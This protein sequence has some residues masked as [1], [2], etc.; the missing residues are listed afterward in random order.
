[1]RAARIHEFGAPLVVEDVPEPHADEGEQL[2][3]LTHAGVNPLDLRVGAGGAGRVPLPFIPGCDGVGTTDAGP[4]VVYG[5]GIGLRRPGTYAELVAAPAARLVPVPPGVAATQAAGLGMAAVTAYGLVHGRAAIEN[6]ERVLVL[7]ASG[8][9]GILTVQLLRE[10]RV[11]TWALCSTIADAEHIRSLGAGEV[12]VGGPESVAEARS[13]APTT[14]VDPLGGPFTGAA[15]QVVGTGGRIAVLGS[16]A[17]TTGALDFGLLYRKAA[18]V[19]GHAT[20]AMSGTQ[21]R[22]ALQHCLDALATGRLA[23]HVDDVVGLDDVEQAH[24]RLRLRRA[25]GKLVLAMADGG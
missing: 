20:L 24:E 11:P 5:G 10:A 19:F 7:G 16:A 9:V 4:V 3:R 2:V 13:W 22:A 17:G 21:V 23:V 15:L 1:M 14:V 6:D 12:L 18:T 25:T 8:G